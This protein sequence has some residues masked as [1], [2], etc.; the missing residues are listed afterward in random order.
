MSNITLE[1]VK[2]SHY[3]VKHLK[4]LG[5]KLDFSEDKLFRIQCRE[6]GKTLKCFDSFD[7]VRMF[8]LGAQVQRERQGNV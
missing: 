3:V 1:D 2:N 5:M 8:V 6:T 4:E 7:N